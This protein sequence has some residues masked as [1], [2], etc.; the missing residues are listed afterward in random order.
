MENSADSRREVGERAIGRS[1]F[2]TGVAA[3]R[4]FRGDHATAAVIPSKLHPRAGK[5][6]MCL[7]EIMVNHAERA[8][9]QSRVGSHRIGSVSPCK[10]A[11]FPEFLGYAHAGT[12]ARSDFKFKTSVSSSPTYSLNPD[13]CDSHESIDTCFTYGAYHLPSRGCGMPSL[14]L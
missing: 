8:L 13:T 9:A 10:A 2:C 12:R 1:K 4:V 3:T 6:D 11:R 5:G 14:S 7:A